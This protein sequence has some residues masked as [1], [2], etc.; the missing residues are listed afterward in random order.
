ME[1]KRLTADDV[2]AME[3]EVAI[4]NEIRHPSVLGLREV[5]EGG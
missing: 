1:K 2:K 3:N 5:R 4:L